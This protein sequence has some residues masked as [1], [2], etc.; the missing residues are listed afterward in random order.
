[1]RAN[2]KLTVNLKDENILKVITNAYGLFCA[3]RAKAGQP[4]ISLENWTVSILLEGSQAIYTFDAQQKAK[5]SAANTDI[6]KGSNADIVTDNKKD[7]N[8]DK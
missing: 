6:L 3:Y 2:N 4:H 5:A 8:A 7:S 1:M